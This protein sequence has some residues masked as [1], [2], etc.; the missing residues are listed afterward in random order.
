MNNLLMAECGVDRG[1][2][3]HPEVFSGLHNAV[4]GID[5]TGGPR[6][7]PH[8]IVVRPGHCGSS[9]LD[10]VIVVAQPSTWSLW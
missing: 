10:L 5:L 2:V 3:D 7:A 8:E 1:P 6:K 4:R 9:T